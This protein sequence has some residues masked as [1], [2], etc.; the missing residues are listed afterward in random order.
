MS[1]FRPSTNTLARLAFAA[2]LAGPVVALAFVLL[3]AR[4]PFFTNQ[5]FPVQQPVQFD[6]RHHAADDG[7]DCRYC[8]ALATRSST[9]GLPSSERCLGCHAQI[10]N[11]SPLLEPVRESFFSDRPIPWR[12][13]HTL[14]GFV[15]FNHSAHLA[16]GIGCRSCHGRVDQM[17]AVE[18]VSPLN[19]GWCLGCHRAPEA[20]LRPPEQI[21]SMTWEP[22]PDRERLARE[23]AARYQVH[24]RVSCSTCHR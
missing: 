22:P 12:R 24:A 5:A 9:A 17:P 23:L 7:I 4:T 20:E 10:W 15:F 13:V 14:P 6:H 3:Y 8:H 1:V 18:Q 2:L 11:K 21:A 19:M 16:K